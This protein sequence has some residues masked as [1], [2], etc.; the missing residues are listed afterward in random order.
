M[1]VH[2]FDRSKYCDVQRSQHDYT[3]HE[4]I[5]SNNI[6]KITSLH[7]VAMNMEPK[8]ALPNEILQS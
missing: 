2:N 8:N 7:R 1:Q 5:E 3:T 4:C 6:A